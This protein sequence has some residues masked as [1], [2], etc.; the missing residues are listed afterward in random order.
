M[1]PA[2]TLLTVGAYAQHRGVSPQQVSRWKREERLVVVHGRIDA[3]ASDAALDGA[4]DAADSPHGASAADPLDRASR[5]E[6]ER[7]KAVWQAKRLRLE[8]RKAAGELVS[9]EQVGREAFHVARTVRDRLQRLPSRLRDELAAE[10]DPAAVHALLE[11][12][13]REALVGLSE[14]LEWEAAR[15]GPGGEDAAP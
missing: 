12:E 11:R 15:S 6:A 1:P 14:D 2:R 5:S 9:K 13:I 7:Q 8:Y 10:D 3:E 4:L